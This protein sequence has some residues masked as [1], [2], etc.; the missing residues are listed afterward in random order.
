MLIRTGKRSNPQLS[1]NTQH[2]LDT[3]LPLDAVDFQEP[4]GTLIC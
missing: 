2:T 4:K 3:F 1:A